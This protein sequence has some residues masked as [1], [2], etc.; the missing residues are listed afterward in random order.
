MT[1]RIE[2][3]TSILDQNKAEAIE[4][5]DLLGKD[6]FVDYAIIASSLGQKHTV[7][8]LDH[9]KKGLKPDEHFNNVD[10]SGDWIVIDL[11]DI[12]IHIMTPEYRIKYDMESFLADLSHAN[13]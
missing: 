1:N 7:A 8:L 9:L 3:I 10:E 13:E 11:G 6:Y 12:L 5:F 2:K 4:V